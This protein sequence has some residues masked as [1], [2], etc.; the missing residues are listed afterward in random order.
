MSSVAIIENII[1]RQRDGPDGAGG[2]P[3][4]VISFHLVSTVS[5]TFPPF[6]LSLSEL[7]SD[8]S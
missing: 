8:Q 1:I 7:Y 4:S 3:H 5:P 6:S 2:L